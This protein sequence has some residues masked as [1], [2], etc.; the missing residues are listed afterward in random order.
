MELDGLARRLDLDELVAPQA[1]VALVTV[2]V[3]DPE[4]CPPPWRAEPV[5]GDHRLGELADHVSTEA[6]P[7]LP[8]E[9]QAQA[10]RF[11]HRR[12]EIARQD[13][14]FEHDEQA[15]R[16]SGECHQAMEAI[17]DPGHFGWWTGRAS[18]QPGRVLRRP[19]P[20]SGGR[21][22]DDEQVARPTAE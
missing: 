2:G 1:G 8:L 15:L 18:R 17:P 19:S 22:V 6:Q 16:S 14:W 20:A 13:R 9:L 4:L 7:A 10:C 11:G 5:A 12:P 3:E 21:Q